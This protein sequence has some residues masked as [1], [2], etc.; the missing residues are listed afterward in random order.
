MIA[1]SIP[2]CTLGGARV[3]RLRRRDPASHSRCRSRPVA[4][5]H[6]A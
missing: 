1:A 6:D 3:A 4:T 5:P 2:G